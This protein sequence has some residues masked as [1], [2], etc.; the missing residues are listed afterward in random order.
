MPKKILIIDDMP[1]VRAEIKKYLCPPASAASMM[2]DLIKKKVTAV[3]QDYIV[4]EAGQGL[5]GVKMV[6]QAIAEDDRYDSII[7]DMKMPPGIDGAE[8]LKKIRQLDEEVKVIVCTAF[9][10]YTE[11]ELQECNGGKP[12]QILTKLL[13]RQSLLAALNT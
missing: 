2:A 11:K 4:K 8:T 12:I 6:A 13:T 9:T 3:D 5:D 7:L 1:M 10:D